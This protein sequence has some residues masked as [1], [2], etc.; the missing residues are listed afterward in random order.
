M[1]WLQDKPVI[2]GPLAK[3]VGGQISSPG[4]P[5]FINHWVKQMQK[6]HA[7]GL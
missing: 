1:G 7:H 2:L 3:A 6:L 4:A 5:C